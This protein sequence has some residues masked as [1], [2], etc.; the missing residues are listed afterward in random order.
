MA[1]SVPEP[2]YSQGSGE[3][4]GERSFDPDQKKIEVKFDSGGVYHAHGATEEIW[5]TFREAPSA[6]SY[7]HQV[8]ARGCPVEKIV[9]KEDS[10][11]E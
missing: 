8:I 4:L 3:R 7:W 2:F 1:F 5:N 11:A 9:P 10:S 6:R